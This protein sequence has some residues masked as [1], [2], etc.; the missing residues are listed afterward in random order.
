MDLAYE[1]V[2]RIL[3]ENDPEG[4]LRMGAPEDEYDH[5]AR[6][7]HRSLSALHRKPDFQ[8]ILELVEYV[9][10]TAFDTIDGSDVCWKK[11]QYSWLHDQELIAHFIAFEIHSLMK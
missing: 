11:E 5:E 3:I 1:D 10:Y 7:I 9:F 2:R 4:L 8:Y 6:T